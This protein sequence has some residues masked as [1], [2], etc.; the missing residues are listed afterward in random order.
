MYAIDYNA[1][2]KDFKKKNLCSDTQEIFSAIQPG[3]VSSALAVTWS[4][5]SNI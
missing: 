2:K 5:C 4:R 3:S 1:I